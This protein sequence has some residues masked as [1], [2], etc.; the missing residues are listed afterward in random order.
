[1]SARPEDAGDGATLAGATVAVVGLGVVGGSLVRA[2]AA[3]S[4]GP[5]VLGA[6]PNAADRAGAERAG[7][8]RTAVEPADLIAEAHVV[9]YAAPLSAILEML[10][11]H[12][13]LLRGD[14]LVT[15]VGGLKAP[16]LAAAAAAGL[17]DRFVGSHPMAGG[18]GSGF[19]GGRADLFRGAPVHLCADP[20]V[21]AARRARAE[22]LWRAVQARPAWVDPA[23]HDR[24]MVRV[25]HLP[26]LV[27]NALALALEDQ[28]VSPADLGPGGRDMTRLARSSPHMW[29][30]LLAHTAG[31]A[32]ALLRAVAERLEDLADRLERGDGVGVAELMTRTRAWH[33][34]PVDQAKDEEP[35]R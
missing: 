34:T 27:A 15:D 10:P 25:S 31:E 28:N 5:R 21:D 17:R 1:M 12:A 26:Q 18:E 6:S 20:A 4:G 9:V 30:D 29:T 2:L 22:A 32:G 16:V 11:R 3:M 14:A 8:A 23:A 35:G 33:G 13:A 19:E 24:L 7:A